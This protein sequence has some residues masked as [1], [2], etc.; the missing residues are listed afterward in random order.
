MKQIPLNEIKKRTIK[1]MKLHHKIAI[2]KNKKMI[3][4]KTR[5][6]IDARSFNGSFL[7]R[8]NNY[9]LVVIMGKN[10]LGKII[11]VK[12]IRATSHYLVAKLLKSEKK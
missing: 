2:E 11:D 7:G 5:V 9:K 6:F 12:I 4:Q 1:L 3:G 8:L 10:L